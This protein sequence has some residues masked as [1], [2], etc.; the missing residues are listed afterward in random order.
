[1]KWEVFR[2]A[3]RRGAYLVALVGDK[4]SAEQCALDYMALSVGPLGKDMSTMGTHLPA[5]GHIRM[6]QLG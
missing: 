1:M 6:V 4:E 5:T 2:G 3:N